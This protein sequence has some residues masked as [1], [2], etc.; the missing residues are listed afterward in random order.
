MALCRKSFRQQEELRCH[1]N[2]GKVSQDPKIK[3]FSNL[4]FFTQSDT[5]QFL[6]SAWLHL[7][8]QTRWETQLQGTEVQVDGYR[9]Q[10]AN[11]AFPEDIR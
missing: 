1:R 9:G 6:I 2:G 10:S 5:S 11:M 4:Q 7:Y 8:S 3:K